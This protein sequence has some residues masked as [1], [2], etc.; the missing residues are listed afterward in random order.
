[1]SARTT[2][3]R[4]PEPALGAS[5]GSPEGLACCFVAGGRV[6]RPARPLPVRSAANR[7]VNPRGDFVHG[8]HDVLHR[9]DPAGWAPIDVF[10]AAHLEK[11]SAREPVECLQRSTHLRPAR[12]ARIARRVSSEPK[13]DEDPNERNVVGKPVDQDVRLASAQL[14]RHAHSVHETVHRGV[15]VDRARYP[16]SR[17]A[18]QPSPAPRSGPRPRQRSTM[19]P[20]CLLTSTS[21][22]SEI[23]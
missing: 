7:S 14:G 12:R 18:R 23:S 8:L 6:D 3:C 22:T 16:A 17:D 1:M 4:D 20:A 15:P 21:L 5:G 13:V 9:R 2:T 11:A 10:D 19:I